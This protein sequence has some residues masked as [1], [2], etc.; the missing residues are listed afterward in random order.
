MAIGDAAHLAANSLDQ[1]GTGLSYLRPDRSGYITAEEY[2][3][4]T[5]E[6]LDE[7]S[8]KGRQMTMIARLAAEHRCTIKVPPIE[9]RVYFTKSK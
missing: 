1:L 8:T 9:R 7:F 6:E 2:E 5:G 3:R 4:I